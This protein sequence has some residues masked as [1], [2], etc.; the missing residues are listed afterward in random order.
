[1]FGVG[2]HRR[3]GRHRGCRHRW[4]SER[5]RCR[6]DANR[7]SRGSGQGRWQG[8]LLRRRAKRRCR[9]GWC[10]RTIDLRGLGAVSQQSLAN[11]IDPLRIGRGG[12]AANRFGGHRSRLLGGGLRTRLGFANRLLRQRFSVLRLRKGRGGHADRR[13]CR[14]DGRGLFR[15]QQR[16]ECRGGVG[17]DLAAVL[18]ER[19]DVAANQHAPR[20]GVNA[21]IEHGDDAGTQAL[22]GRL[23]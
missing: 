1:M 7:C 19:H 14:R 9:H 3:W 10:F 20:G 11:S 6:Y 21:F 15:C 18:L 17:I 5:R 12:I 4:C 23:D 13:F 16:L 8:E 2:L 22:A